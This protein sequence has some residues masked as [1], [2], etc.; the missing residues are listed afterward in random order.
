M[1]LDS[2]RVSIET[3]RL[4]PLRTILSTLGIV[5]GVAALVAVLSLADGMEDYMRSQ[6]GS[7]TDVQAIG[8]SPRT[9]REVEGVQVP[10][11]SVARWSPSEV[12]A[13]AAGLPVPATAGLTETGY[14]VTMV[15]G[16]PRVTEV[17]GTMAQIF[18][19][20]GLTFAAGRGFAEADTNARVA[21]ITR[22]AARTLSPAARPP[23]AVGDSVTL[24]AQHLLVIAILGGSS[25]DSRVGAVVPIGIAPLFSRPGSRWA[26]SM[27][28]Q[29]GRV[30][31]VTAARDGVERWLASRHG[32]GWKTVARVASRADRA[33]Q[34]EQGMLVF[35][36]VMGAITGI[37]LLVG[38]IGVMNVLLAAVVE[39]TR[40]IGVRRAVGAARRHILAQFLAESVTIST[41]GSV[42]GILLGLAG[43]YGITALIR[44]KTKALIFAGVSVGTV[45]VAV[46]ATV[47]VG[48]T[49]GIY[50]A[51]T[52][53]RLSPIDA[54]R[55]E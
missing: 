23:L 2:F 53:S 25:T 12:T 7:T 18:A 50:P 5:I 36:L 55:H 19:A 41:A 1:L 4:S 14:A 45:A 22:K 51:L 54:I 34:A 48:L 40:E 11:D 32:S 46:I 37:C 31:D 6:I 38:G 27:I 47:L 29:A 17:M 13:L 10:L 15:D 42:V 49:F 39:R 21:I 16:V 24:G 33:R 52:A 20:Q 26:P 9:M 28:V 43:S 44:M 35:R 3:L 30:E 8:V